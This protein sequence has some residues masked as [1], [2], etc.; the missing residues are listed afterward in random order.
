MAQRKMNEVPS[1]GR[2]ALIFGATGGTGRYI[3]RGVLTREA[4]DE[5]TVVG[6]KEFSLNKFGLK[7]P[8][9][10]MGKL[11]NIVVP[12]LQK[13]LESGELAS[14]F[15]AADTVFITLGVP[16]ENKKMTPL[17]EE[18]LPLAIYKEAK[19]GG[20]KHMSIITSDGEKTENESMLLAKCH[21]AKEKGAIDAGFN[22]LT[23]MKPG[24]LDRQECALRIST[25]FRG[26]GFK[27]EKMAAIM[28]LDAERVDLEEQTEVVKYPSKSMKQAYKELSS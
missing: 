3:V 23:V 18:I 1:S 21:Y 24:L 27:V 12:D 25:L 8:E 26:T 9:A 7:A 14:A 28:V 16:I 6:R 15:A 10:S 11:K 22:N 2:K 17:V 5:I 20:I 4:W 13:A 19:K